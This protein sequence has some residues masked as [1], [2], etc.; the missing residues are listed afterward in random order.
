VEREPVNFEGATGAGLAGVLTIPDGEARA[1][2]LLSHCFTCGK[3]VQTLSRL[4]RNLAA[5]GHASLRY[6][7]TG[8]GD[9]EGDFAETTLTTNVGDVERAAAFLAERDLGPLVL[10]GHS[11]GGVASLLAAPRIDA[12]RAV[13]TLNASSRPQHLA[14]E[15]AHVE[16]EVREQGTA[17]VPVAG[18]PFRLSAELFDDLERHDLEAALAELNRPLLILQCEHDTLVELHHGEALYAAAHEP[19]ELVI[20]HG[21][22]HLLTDKEIAQEA[23]DQV[24]AWLEEMLG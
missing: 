11:L 6:D 20:L 7:V 10:L 16:D 12:A 4:A 14:D 3:D 15:L 17:T 8:V 1:A 19:K 5:S 18:R 24:A 13:I 2:L 21:G 9:S 23:A 22:D